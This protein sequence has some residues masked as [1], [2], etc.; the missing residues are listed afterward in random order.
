M[1]V[2]NADVDNGF[3]DKKLNFNQNE[4]QTRSLMGLFFLSL[5][6]YDLLRK[7]LTNSIN[8]ETK[9]I[10]QKKFL[11]NIIHF[12]MFD[13]QDIEHVMFIFKMLI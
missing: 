11:H 5:I 12:V 9:E 1:F 8:M 4:Q 2:S 3:P 6:M 10:V 7:N 13:Q